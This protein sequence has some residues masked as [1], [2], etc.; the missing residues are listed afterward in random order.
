MTEDRARSQRRRSREIA[1]K[2]IA[3]V[4]RT[5]VFAHVALVGLNRGAEGVAE[6]S[7]CGRVSERLSLLK[8]PSVH[9]P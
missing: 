3:Y 4:D 1:A 9:V 2:D 8:V 7:T 6:A 5:R